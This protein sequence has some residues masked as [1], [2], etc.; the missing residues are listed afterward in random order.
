ELG[1]DSGHH[2]RGQEPLAERDAAGVADRVLEAARPDVLDEQQPGRMAGGKRGGNPLDVLA[3]EAERVA[4]DRVRSVACG[5]NLLLEL[6]P[7]QG[8]DDRSEI[9]ALMLEGNE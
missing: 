2:L 5:C 7:E 1:P 3:R 8:A 9:L 6:E 4:A